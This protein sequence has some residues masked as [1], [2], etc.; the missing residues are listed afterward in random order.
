[1]R[2]SNNATIIMSFNVAAFH[3]GDPVIEVSR[4]FNTDVPEISARQQLG[5]TAFDASRSFIDHV[6]PYPR[7]H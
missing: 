4:L 2:A 5:A 3:D 6:T 1:M 7:Q